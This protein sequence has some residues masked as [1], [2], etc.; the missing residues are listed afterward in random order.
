MI[1][2]PNRANR[3]VRTAAA[4]SESPFFLSRLHSPVIPRI[5]LAC[6]KMTDAAF[7]V[8]NRGLRWPTALPAALKRLL[9]SPE[10][11]KGRSLVTTVRL[12]E[13]QRATAQGYFF[14]LAVNWLMGRYRSSWNCRNSVPWNGSWTCH[15]RPSRRCR[16]RKSS[17]AA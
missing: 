12:P 14:W 9:C 10:W 17:A 7:P 16:R 3:C 4:T 13:S 11:R 2:S 8:F 15:L 1:Y 6:E 5:T